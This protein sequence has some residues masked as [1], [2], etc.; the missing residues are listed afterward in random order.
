VIQTKGSTP[1]ATCSQNVHWHAVAV[2]ESLQQRHYKLIA[3]LHLGGI[4]SVA[5]NKLGLLALYFLVLA[6]ASTVAAAQNFPN[7]LRSFRQ[8]AR[9][10]PKRN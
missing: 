3:S 9:Y 7:T 5:A 4:L 10:I 6:S 8:N 2:S 1:K